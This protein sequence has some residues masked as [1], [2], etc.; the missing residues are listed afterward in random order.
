LGMPDKKQRAF[1]RP[2]AGLLLLMIL[3]TRFF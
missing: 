2:G 1:H 3:A